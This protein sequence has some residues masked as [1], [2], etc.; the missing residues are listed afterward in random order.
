[1]TVLDQSA[2][3]RWRREPCRFIEEVCR[4]P[5]TGQPFK[6]LDAERAFLDHAFRVD[7]SGRLIYPEQ[8]YSA[9]KKSGKTGFAALHALTTTLIFGGTHGEATLAANDQDQ[10]TGRVF[11]A[12]ARIVEASPLLRGEA[13]VLSDRIEFSTGAT[14]TAIASDYAGAAGGNPTISVFD[15]LWAYT[16]ERSRR[17]W[18]ELVPPPT[19]KIAC[20]LTV[21][22]AGFEGESVLLEELYRR[23]LSLP[24]VGDSL[25]AGGGLLMAWHHEPIAPWQTLEWLE[26]MRGQLRPNAFLR[27]IENRFVSGE[28]SFIEPGW[29]D[30]C[31]DADA[32]PLLADKELPVWVGVDASVKRDSTAVVAVSWDREVNKVRLV[33]HRIFQPTKAQP[34]DFEAT[35][36]RTVRDLCSRFAVRGVYYDPYQ[37]ASVSQRLAGAGVP[38]REY[39]QTEANLTAMGSNLFEL[40]KGA[41]LV[42]YPDDG[43]RLAMN[44]AIA[45]ETPRGWK[46]TKE[47]SSHK[48]D[49]IVALAMASLAAVEHSR[50]ETPATYDFGVITTPRHYFGD[51]NEAATNDAA[52]SY[53]MG[54]GRSFG[55][56]TGG[57]P[58]LGGFKR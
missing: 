28:S 51:A 1:M 10:A 44:R 30:R 17:L 35:V 32:V 18:D 37:M 49:V 47:K 43:I 40:V 36:E 42:T 54:G 39:P 27:M 19:R 57:N 24:C 48:I 9:P 20:R 14:I 5:E 3:S 34:L 41:N 8:V 12:I 6:L 31:V 52:A 53:L 45:K 50:F 29:F 2:L 26:Q 21:T 25:Y 13:R 7:D 22:Y 38:M 58:F 11:L 4:D 56:G 15:E 23:G 16:S 55:G 33:S 46:I